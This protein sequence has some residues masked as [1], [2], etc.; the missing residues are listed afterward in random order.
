[1]QH[2]G[3]SN[4]FNDNHWTDWTC[5]FVAWPWF[6]PQQNLAQVFQ[7]SMRALLFLR[8]LQ[9][10][11]SPVLPCSWSHFSQFVLMD[12]LRFDKQMKKFYTTLSFLEVLC[13]WVWW[14][15]HTRKHRWHAGG[16]WQKCVRKHYLWQHH[17]I[18]IDI[19]PA[20]T[21][22]HHE[23]TLLP[24]GN[25]PGSSYRVNMLPWQSQIPHGSPRF[26]TLS[27]RRIAWRIDTSS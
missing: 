8:R 21:Y 16:Y 4:R 14:Q 1:M 18:I 5:C 25:I 3:E 10:C 9:L 13:R 26:N 27:M 17:Y 15:K 24:V 7:L 12:H 19:A 22:P 2:G 11:S 23:Y 20:Q 6:F